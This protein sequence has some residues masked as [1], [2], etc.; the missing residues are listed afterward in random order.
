M[1]RGVRRNVPTHPGGLLPV[2]AARSCGRDAHGIESDHVI[3]FT[4]NKVAAE[5]SRD[6]GGNGPT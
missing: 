1:R 6:K 5:V 3:D 2:A 4:V